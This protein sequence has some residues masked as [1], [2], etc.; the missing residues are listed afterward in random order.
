MFEVME[1]EIAHSKPRKNHLPIQVAL[2]NLSEEVN[3][4]EIFDLF[5][6]YGRLKEVSIHYNDSGKSLGKD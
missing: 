1:K 6:C 5:S 4:S 3:E 2:S